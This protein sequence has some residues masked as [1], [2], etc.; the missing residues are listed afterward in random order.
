MEYLTD[1]LKVIL[2]L[3]VL[4]ILLFAQIKLFVISSNLKKTNNLLKAI[5]IELRGKI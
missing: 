1:Y 5:L 4:F 3:F 2:G